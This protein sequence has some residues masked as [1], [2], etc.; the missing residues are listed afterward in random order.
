[1]VIGKE[2]FGAVCAALYLEHCHI[3][4]LAAVGNAYELA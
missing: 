3:A 2:Y 4:E 1:V